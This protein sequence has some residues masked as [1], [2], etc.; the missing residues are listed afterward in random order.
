MTDSPPPVS[1]TDGVAST[2]VD[3]AKDEAQAGL[4]TIRIGRSRDNDIVLGYPFISAHHARLTVAGGRALLEDLESRNGTSVNSP[5][6]RIARAEITAADTVYFGTLPMP[7][8]RLLG[9]RLVQGDAPV[10]ELTLDRSTLVLGRHPNCDVVLS[11]PSVSRQ[12]ARVLRRAGTMRVEDLGST[13]GT[14]VNGRRIASP[15]EIVAGDV[16]AIGGHLLRLAS[17]GTLVESQWRG[18]VTVEA[19]GV[20]VDGGGRRLLDTVSLTVFP[21]ELVGVMGPSGAG[22]TTLLNALN[23]Y[24]QPVAGQVLF[25]GVDLYGSYD[26][27]RLQIGYV[28][29]DDIMHRELT[30]REALYYTA[31]LRLPADTDDAEIHARIDSVLAELGIAGLDTSRIGTPERKGISGGERKRVNIAMELLT[32]PS[33]LFLDEP[34]SG[35]SSEDALMV[36]HVLRRLADGGRTVIL[37]IHQPSVDAFE[38]L[39][40]VVVVGKDA[41]RSPG[42]LV[43]FGP[44]YPEA[45]DF[46]SPSPEVERRHAD[47]PTPEAMLRGLATA[48]ASAWT[49]KY[50]KSETRR[51]FVE[52]RANSRETAVPAPQTRRARRRPGLR[53]WWTLVRRTAAVKAGDLDN[54][55]ML[56]VQAPV[57]AL[58]TVVVFGPQTRRELTWES[59][60]EVAGALGST[61]FMLSVAA[62]W[63]GCSN[64]AREI[65][66]EWAVYKR[67]RMVN[68]KIPSYIAAKLTL[69]GAI[70]AVQCATMAGI[71]T[72][73]CGLNAPTAAVFGVLLLAS[74]VGLGCG[75]LLSAYARTSEVAISLVPTLLLPMIMLGGAMA[76]LPD[77]SRP[78]RAVA[79]AMPT[80]WSF[81]AL[82][83]LESARRPG[84]EEPARDLIAT[85]GEEPRSAEKRVVDLHFPAD[86]RVGL[87]SGV[88]V[89]A[90]MTAVMLLAIIAI[91]RLRDPL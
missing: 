18:N 58:F 12:H 23:G 41:P 15:A 31:R 3:P 87:S 27:F 84:W 75:L 61:M 73:G 36:A 48:D 72:L 46:F 63:L 67:E 45:I 5:A 2:I 47:R 29:Q 8:T 53:Q 22:K 9:D 11:S 38:L 70:G 54:L 52:S 28:P 78:V 24:S 69:L 76:P 17:E 82:M 91:L 49:A 74:L 40:E 7:A 81:E 68:L 6:R 21:S 57:I 77:M 51:R 42:R 13:N 62:I 55:V 83:V 25:N 30:V 19:R 60:P 4:R 37:T 44:A 64:A 65:V 16:V 85:N 1:L 26:Q 88:G 14:F 90:A 39:D 59:W 50:E 56:F 34:T 89:L 33:V 20:A 10:R 35:L 80:R 66:A 86:V 71:V 79:Q 43:Y 32:D